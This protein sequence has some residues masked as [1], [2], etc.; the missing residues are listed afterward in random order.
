MFKNR[1]LRETFGAERGEVT[2]EWSKICFEWLH[3]SV[4]SF[5][6]PQLN[7]LNPAPNKIPG[8]A[9]VADDQTFLG[10]S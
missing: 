2:G 6:C 10:A 7:L 1:G 4:L 8:Y 3:D 9:T 5:L